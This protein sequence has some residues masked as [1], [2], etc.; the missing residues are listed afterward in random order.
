M[1]VTFVHSSGRST[2]FL[3][4]VSVASATGP[5]NPA[6][7]RNDLYLGVRPG[8][9]AFKGLLDEP[10]IYSRALTPAEI[11]SIFKAGPAGKRL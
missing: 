10:A 2:I 4:G 9:D 5:A 6:E 8:L 1:A 7:T 3:N 11:L